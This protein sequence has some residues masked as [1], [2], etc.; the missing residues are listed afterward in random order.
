MSIKSGGIW[1]FPSA[2]YRVW[3]ANRLV[4]YDLYASFGCEIDYDPGEALLTYRAMLAE[5]I[6]EALRVLKQGGNIVS[7][8]FGAVPQTLTP[9]E[10]RLVK[11]FKSRVNR[12]KPGGKSYDE[13]ALCREFEAA[14]LTPTRLELRDEIL[15]LAA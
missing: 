7:H 5:D 3:A 6:P 10:H 14:Q 12:L 11:L 4:G 2:D 9:L 8:D 1:F 15:Q 13:H